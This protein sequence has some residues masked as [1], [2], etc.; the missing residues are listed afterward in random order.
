MIYEKLFAQT[1]K[2]YLAGIRNMQISLG[3][4]EPKEFSSQQ[5]LSGHP[6]ITTVHQKKTH[7]P[8]TP[9]ILHK[10]RDYWFQGTCKNEDAHMLWAAATICFFGFVR[11]EE[12]TVPSTST[13]LPAQ[14][15][16]WGDVAINSHS[17]TTMMKVHLKRSQNVIKWAKEW[18][19]W[20]E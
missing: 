11:S 9:G 7:L 15:L 1:I 12:I 3:Q 10:Q 6:P 2:T 20:V 4:S 17:A 13:F 19:Y 5:R 18:I 16:T 8:L 14:H